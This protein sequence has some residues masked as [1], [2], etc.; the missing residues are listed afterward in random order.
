MEADEAF[1]TLFGY[2]SQALVG[3][4]FDSLLTKVSQILFQLH[5]S[6]SLRLNGKSDGVQFTLKSGSTENVQIVVSARAILIE[7]D[8]CYELL[9]SPG[10]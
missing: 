10:R 3:I 2:L 5:F 6:P 8:A 1:C 9:V 7:N 4:R